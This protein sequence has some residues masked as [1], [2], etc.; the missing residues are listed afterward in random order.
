ML[1][2]RLA[3]VRLR[4]HRCETHQ[5]HQPLHVLTV[6]DG[7]F[8]AQRFAKLAA[9]VERPLQMDL[10]DASHQRQLLRAG[11]YRLVVQPRATDSQQLTLAPKRNLFL[12]LNHGSAL[13]QRGRASPRAKKSRST[14]S[15][16]IFSSSS[17]SRS[18]PLAGSP[19]CSNT[20][21]ARSMNSFFHL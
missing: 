12:N 13:L 11:A 17:F 14:V 18:E 5:A 2:V 9:A 20:E 7:P 4:R 10:V 6:D 15:S 21:A 16:P 8:D 1:G 3:R 19:G